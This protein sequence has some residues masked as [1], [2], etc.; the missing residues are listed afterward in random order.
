[1]D[2]GEVVIIIQ[3]DPGDGGKEEVDK[4]GGELEDG[5]EMGG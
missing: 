1:M 4:Y 3:S 2:E 5:R